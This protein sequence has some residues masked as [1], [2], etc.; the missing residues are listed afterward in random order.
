MRVLLA[1]DLQREFD[2]GLGNFERICAFARARK[3]YDRV[4]ATRCRNGPESPFVRYDNWYDCQGEILPLE[5][6][7]DL[8]LDKYAYGLPDY[9]VLDRKDHYDIIG[10]N[11]DACVLKVALD[12]FDRGYDISVLTEYCFSSEGEEDHRYGVKLLRRLMSRAVI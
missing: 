11:T 9:S 10:F 4:I 2:D 5:F 7:A 1:V 8:V 12:L 3:G 6:E